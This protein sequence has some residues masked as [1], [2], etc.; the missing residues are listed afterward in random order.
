[1][2]NFDVMQD[3]KTLEIDSFIKNKNMIAFERKLKELANDCDEETRDYEECKGQT[4]D[5]EEC[6]MTRDIEECDETRD[7]EE[8]DAQTHNQTGCDM[9]TSD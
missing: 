7:F 4:R 8:C 1:M 5:F 9:E 2:Q 3:R 6:D